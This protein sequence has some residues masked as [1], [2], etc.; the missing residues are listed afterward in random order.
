MNTP[1]QPTQ[2][3]SRSRSAD[4]GRIP[5]PAAESVWAEPG[6]KLTDLAAVC[7]ESGASGGAVTFYAAG[8]QPQTE[9]VDSAAV[10]PHLGDLDAHLARHRIRHYDLYGEHLIE[11][12]RQSLGESAYQQFIAKPEFY[13]LRDMQVGLVGRLFLVSSSAS[14]TFFSEFL[15]S[16][17]TTGRVLF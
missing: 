12:L 3:P 6:R 16:W 13:E 7:A 9:N 5:K 4:I 2:T 17:D 10:C 15:F 8:I 1:G 11:A 14:S